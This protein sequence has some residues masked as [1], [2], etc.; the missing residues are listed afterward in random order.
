[1]GSQEVFFNTTMPPLMT[2]ILANCNLSSKIKGYAFI[3]EAFPSDSDISNRI[4]NRIQ[5]DAPSLSVVLPKTNG[6]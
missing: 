2:T 5:L 3:K 1:M 6:V 4:A